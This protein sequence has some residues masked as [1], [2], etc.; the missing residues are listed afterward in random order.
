MS[1]IVN[2]SEVARRR[3]ELE[4]YLTANVLDGT[5]VCEH[6]ASCRRSHPAT[7]YEG[8]LHHV[9]RYYGLE[10]Q[11]V[12]FR[13]VVVGQEYGHPPARVTMDDRYAMVMD[14]GLR[15]RFKGG[16]GYP[17]RNPHMKGTTSAL[18]L[19][20]GISLGSDY[21]SEVLSVNEQQCQIF[22]TFALVNYLL[23]SAISNTGSRRGKAT[24]LMKWNCREHFRES[25]RI[26]DPTVI[27]VQG[28]GFWDSCVRASFDDVTHL[29][30]SV[31]EARIGTL[32]TFVAALAH[33]SA[34][35]P[36]NWGTNEKTPYLLGTVVPSLQWIRQQ[37][38]L[39]QLDV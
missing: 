33:P 13:I 8:Q 2:Q 32:R 34:G 29:T 37:L 38:I 7:F 35:P 22:D 23:C 15:H 9:G 1:F 10:N 28:K 18:R 17:A 26:L 12:P 6:Y 24:D 19:L 21:P 14:S 39:G 5:C 4:Q 30:D 3:L 20:L 36:N 31:Y 25:L 11:G 27:V 16:E